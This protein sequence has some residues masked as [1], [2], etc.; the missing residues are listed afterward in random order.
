LALSERETNPPDVPAIDLSEVRL[1]LA[2]ACARLQC[3]FA[4]LLEPRDPPDTDTPNLQPR[5]DDDPRVILKNAL[6]Q[7]VS[8]LLLPILC[9]IAGVPN[10]SQPQQRPLTTRPLDRPARES[11]LTD[12]ACDR[13]A[14]RM[15]N[16]KPALSNYLDRAATKLAGLVAQ[17]FEETHLHAVGAFGQGDAGRIARRYYQCFDFFDSVQFPMMFGTEIGEP[18]TVDI[19]RVCPEDSPSLVDEAKER[20]TKLKGLA[21]AHFGAFLDRDWRVSDLLWGRLDGAERLITA[22]LPLKETEGLRNN[23]IDEAHE[24]ILNEFKAR[25]RLGTMALNAATNQGSRQPE[26]QIVRQVIDAI[27]SPAAMATR[28][29]QTDFMSLWSMLL[30]AEPNRIVLMRTLSRGAT[31]AGQMLD[32]I[33]AGSQLSVAGK[34][35]AGAGRA[36]WALVEISVPHHWATLLGRYWQSLL[37]LISIILIAAGLVATQPSVGWAVL[38]LS[39]LLVALRTILWDFMSGSRFRAAVGALVIVLVLAVLYRWA[40][41]W[42]QTLQTSTCSLLGNCPAQVHSPPFSTID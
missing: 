4:R 21:V 38:G 23:L 42:S 9:E 29:N 41:A 32:G 26:T 6:P 13:S 20:R 34:W 14:E 8:A 31:I 18:D 28:Q 12:L 37:L 24:A 39:V 5:G 40:N 25:A 22:L 1:P 36:L 3:V 19:I 2:H 7:N 33:A 35:L 15:L 17:L 30:T 11:R 16:D 27:V 10:D